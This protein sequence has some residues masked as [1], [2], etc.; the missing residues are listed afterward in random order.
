MKFI[1]Q[2]SDDN[3]DGMDSQSITKGFIFRNTEHENARIKTARKCSPGNEATDS[4]ESLPEDILS[5]DE[6]GE[7]LRTRTI[8]FF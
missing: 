5:N 8:R 4:V 2:L 3:R 1:K 6:E 7:A